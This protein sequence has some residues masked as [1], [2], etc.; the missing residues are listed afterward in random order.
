MC[1]AGLAAPAQEPPGPG[2][3][4]RAAAQRLS[5]ASALLEAAEGARNRVRALTEAIRAYEDGLEAMRE[6]LRRAAIREEVLTRELAAR[7][8]EIA[9][10]LGVLQS[11]GTAP[12]PVRMLH[13]GGPLGTARSGMVL[14]DV[15]P[16]LDARA[17]ELRAHLEE[18]SMLR[19]LQSSAADKLRDGLESLQQA[20]TDLSQAIADREELPRRFV[21]DPV[22]TA[23]LVASTDTLEGFA[24]GL[25]DLAIDEAP[26][27][28]PGIADRKGELP[29]PVKG[30]ILRRAGEAD[31]AGITRPGIVVATPPRA[32]VTTP[33][34][35]TVR[36]RGPLLDYGNVI[37]L[38]P[39]AGILLVMAGLDVVYGETGKV[40]PGGSPVGLMGGPG[41]GEDGLLTTT[42]A[43]TGARRTETL[44]IELRKDD[45]PVDPE[46]W[47]R[48]D[49]G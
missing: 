30:T 7:E 14:A 17:G 10:L 44:Y 22:R 19:E 29:L 47:F 23:L 34:P 36:Y 15:A 35:A 31:A 8:D 32:L 4:A 37:I 11:I 45:T 2:E 3:A 24:S 12:A 39:Q 48:T 9:Q 6:G 42:G 33:A 43:G 46:A 18:V 16:A 41:T 40:L 27:S 26:G 13:P 38:E 5:K 49:E 28:L 1:A 25:G 21:E 20:R